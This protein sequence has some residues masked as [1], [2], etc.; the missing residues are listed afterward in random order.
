M[1]KA[2]SWD[3]RSGF[4]LIELL[5]VLFII[6]TVAFISIPRLFQDAKEKEPTSIG[7]Y[8]KALR[9]EA[10]S[11]KKSTTFEINFKERFFTFKGGRGERRVKMEDDETW[12]LFLASRGLIK[13]GEVKVIFPPTISEEFLALYLSKGGNDYTIILNNLNGELEIEEGI[14]KFN[15]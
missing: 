2:P 4:T 8:L 14:K 6:T 12:Q 13:E 3:K 5:V 10:V 7:Q 1:R 15:E 11:T 9:E